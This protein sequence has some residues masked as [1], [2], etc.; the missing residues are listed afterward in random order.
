MTQ[1]AKKMPEFHSVT[2][3]ARERGF[4]NVKVSEELACYLGHKI[5]GRGMSSDEEAKI[6]FLQT[7]SNKLAQV[8]P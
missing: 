4:L 7:L 5:A 8:Q 1:T 2:L 6:T 3:T